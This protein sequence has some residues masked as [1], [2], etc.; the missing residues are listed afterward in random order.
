M[1]DPQALS[2][3]VLSH[4]GSDAAAGRSDIPGLH[5][6]RVMPIR[7]MALMTASF[8]ERDVMAILLC[9][10]FRDPSRRAA[11]GT[12]RRLWD[13]ASRGAPVAAVIA[14]TTHAMVI[15]GIFSGEARSGGEV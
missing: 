6:P 10:R 14:V 2:G 5:P 15:R 1:K 4:F 8:D 11:A 9:S 7:V 12:R 3:A 13:R